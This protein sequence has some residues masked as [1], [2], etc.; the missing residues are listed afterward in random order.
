[1]LKV[2]DII[3]IHSYKH[4]G[5]L[6]RLWETSYMLDETNEMIIVGNKQTKV[7]EKDGR[8]WNSGEPSITVFYKNRWM[9]CICM[10]KKHGLAFYVNLASPSIYDEEGIKYIDYDLDVR[11]S[12]DVPKILDEAEFMRH[13]KEM[14]YQKEITIKIENTLKEIIDMVN[15]KTS[16]FNKEFV[17]KYY[18]KL[19]T[20]V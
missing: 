10:L 1:M 13:K 18:Q 11:I 16:P 2:G 20:L 9:N 15:S 17:D 7:I 3:Q 6:H 12:L 19:L 14:H 5:Q 8:T 4:N